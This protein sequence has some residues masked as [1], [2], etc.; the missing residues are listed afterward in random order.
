MKCPR[1]HKA[2]KKLCAFSLTL[3]QSGFCSFTDGGGSWG[4]QMEELS[5]LKVFVVL[6]DMLQ[7]SY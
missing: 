3:R 2:V 5:S 6:K 1:I 7:Y 4:Q